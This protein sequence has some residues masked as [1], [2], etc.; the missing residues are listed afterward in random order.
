MWPRPRPD[1]EA[2]PRIARVLPRRVRERVF[3]PAYYD[4]LMEQE[5]GGIRG[6]TPR[7]RVLGLIAESL[8]VGGVDWLI[9]DR[10][11]VRAGRTVLSIG[12]VLITLGLLA[13]ALGGRY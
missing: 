3:L 2:T 11:L 8:R 1:H 4:L 13:V 9:R 10:R 12:L 6:P 5:A 7:A